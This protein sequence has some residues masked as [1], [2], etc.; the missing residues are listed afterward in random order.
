M[1]KNIYKRL[2]IILR[3]LLVI[4]LITQV[5][6]CQLAIEDATKNSKKLCGIFLTIGSDWPSTMD[7]SFENVDFKVGK[8]GEIT[9]DEKGIASLNDQEVEG[10]LIDNRT[11]K[12]NGVE[13]YFMGLI[14]IEE[15]GIQSHG[16]MADPE[17][18]KGKLSI[19]VTDA[20]EENSCEITF[21]VATSFDQ[22]VHL[23]PV[24]QRGDGSYYAIRGGMGMLISGDN[25]G[26]THSQTLDEAFTTSSEGTTIQ[27][28]DSFKV[29]IEVVE[30]SDKLIIKEMNQMDELI[31]STEYEH[32]DSKDYNV[33]H[34]TD[35][36]IVEEWENDVL[37]SPVNRSVYSMKNL[38]SDE[39][40][41]HLWNIPWEN[42][43]VIRKEIHF[44]PSK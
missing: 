18:Y 16:L 23:N 13:G 26:S 4:F 1:S 5:T 40:I 37:D 25:V 33:D 12:F 35:Y 17:F 29:N 10:E 6:G 22:G 39:R 11:M 28:K 7:S 38:S 15:D 32:D 41:S 36:I 24:Y 27:R 42:N 19:N 9:L 43:L 8:N 14:E 44:I 34:N 2:R 31:K 3:L 30:P 20:G 21:S